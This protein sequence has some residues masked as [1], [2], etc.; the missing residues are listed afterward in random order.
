MS[1]DPKGFEENPQ[2]TLT[3]D[4]EN[5]VDESIWG[6]QKELTSEEQATYDAWF[7]KKVGRTM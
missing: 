5:V 1:D 6:P 7:R 2:A 3:G 4:D